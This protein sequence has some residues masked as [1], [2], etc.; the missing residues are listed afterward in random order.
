M[1]IASCIYCEKEAIELG[2]FF[3][4]LFSLISCPKK[5]RGT[6]YFR[7]E[8]KL[9]IEKNSDIELDILEEIQETIAEVGNHIS[10]PYYGLQ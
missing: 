3:F 1:S 8:A 9:S 10:N 7:N 2:C 6:H 4:H 5:A